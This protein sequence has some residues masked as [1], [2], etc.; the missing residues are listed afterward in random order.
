VD[1]CKRLCGVSVIRSGESIENALRACCK[2]IKIRK[3]LIHGEGDNSQQLIY[4]KWSNDI[5]EK[6]NV[7]IGPYLWHW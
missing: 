6:A 2:V 3:I 7:A 4:E 5:L 1:F